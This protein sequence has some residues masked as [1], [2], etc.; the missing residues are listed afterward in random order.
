MRWNKVGHIEK[1]LKWDFYGAL[2]CL[3]ISS[4]KDLQRNTNS[5]QIQLVFQFCG[6]DFGGKISFSPCFSEIMDVMGTGAKQNKYTYVFCALNL[7]LELE[8]WYR[9]S[10]RV[11]SKKKTFTYFLRLSRVSLVL[12]WKR[13]LACTNWGQ[14]KLL[15]LHIYPTLV[16]NDKKQSNLLTASLA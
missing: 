2:N 16:F 8:I 11:W 7:E 3:S 9:F 1:E 5:I 4:R 6:F 10:P 13:R 12:Y 15:M 14:S